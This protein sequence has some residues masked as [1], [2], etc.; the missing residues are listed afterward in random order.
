MPAERPQKFSPSYGDFWCIWSGWRIQRP[1]H[2]R[3]SVRTAPDGN[4][5]PDISALFLH[6]RN[7]AAGR[8]DHGYEFAIGVFDGTHCDNNHAGCDNIQRR[9]L[10][11]GSPHLP[12]AAPRRIA[13]GL[14]RCWTARPHFTPPRPHPP[15]C[16]SM[17]FSS[18][19]VAAACTT[20]L[21]HIHDNCPLRHRRTPSS[22]AAL[23]AC[24]DERLFRYQSSSAFA[25]RGSR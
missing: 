12:A 8:G 15:P 10:G 7:A 5:V 20:P 16:A 1:R 21:P 13:I 23:G 11:V 19:Q 14:V 22:R 3:T 4:A 18:P 9:Y 2:I 17:F 6:S 25:D 24:A